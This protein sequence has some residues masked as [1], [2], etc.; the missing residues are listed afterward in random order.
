M[1]NVD[2]NTS[3]NRKTKQVFPTPLS[4]NTTTLNSIGVLS[5]RPVS[6]KYKIS[7]ELGVEEGCN[8]ASSNGHHKNKGWWWTYT[9]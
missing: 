6:L 2:V 5:I 9:V 8:D 4:P 7:E 3:I 1:E